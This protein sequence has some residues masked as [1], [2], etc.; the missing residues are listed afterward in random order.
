LYYSNFLFFR[1]HAP[2]GD[3]LTLSKLF[4]KALL[5]KK[6]LRTPAFTGCNPV[7]EKSGMCE[8]TFSYRVDVFFRL[9]VPAALFV[10]VFKSY[11]SVFLNTYTYLIISPQSLDVFNLLL[12]SN[13]LFLNTKLFDVSAFINNLTTSTFKVLYYVYKLPTFSTWLILFIPYE[14]LSSNLITSPKI[15]SI[16]KLFKAASWAEREV[17]ELFGIFF[18]SKVTNRKLITDYFFKVYPLLK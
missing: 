7:Q 10:T 2:L 1:S 3:L 15:L 5:V 6:K 18:F 8:V 11:R 16:E 12:F 14:N 13:P 9:L 17:S 4:W